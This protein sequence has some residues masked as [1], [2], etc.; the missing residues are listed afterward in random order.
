MRRLG[1][2]VGG[3]LLFWLLTALP[4]RH[5][6][7]DR[8]IAFSGVAISLCVVPTALTLLWSRWAL[9]QGPEQQLVMVLGGT[10]V[11]MFFVLAGGL[12]LYLLV[13]YFQNQQSFW[14]WVLVSYLFTLALEMTL[15]LS[16]GPQVR[17]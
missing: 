7:G 10:G 13:P 4:A 1:I 12:L 17:S 5:I 11:R 8:A 3:S 15:M 9:A 2:L 16:Q 14:V 6:W